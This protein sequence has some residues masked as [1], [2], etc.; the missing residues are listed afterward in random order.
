M[1]SKRIIA[2]RIARLERDLG[3][4]LEYHSISQVTRNNGH[5]N[6]LIDPE[7]GATKRKLKPDEV[8]WIRNERA[9]CQVDFLYYA[10]RYAIVKDWQNRLVRFHP[11]VAQSIL[12]DIMADLEEQGRAIAIMILKARQLGMSTG[13]EI[14]VGHRPQFYPQVN[15]TVASSDPDKS[16][17]MA[18][19]MELCWDHMPWFLMP[20]RT[21][22]KVGELIEYGRQN[23]G[24]AI[25]HGNQFSGISRGT[26]PT[27]AH[28]SE[29]CDY[30]DPAGLIDAS[31][32]R[33][34]HES[35]WMF[36]VLES[37]A[38]G[39]HNWWHNTWELSKQGWKEGTARLY[40]LFLPWFVGRDIYPTETWLR[41]RP[42]PRKW[43]PSELT[44]AHAA[45]AQ[46]YVR[47]NDLLRKHLGENWEMPIEQKW[48][49]E[50]ERQQYSQKKM[51]AQFYSEMPADDIEAFQSTNYSVFDVEVISDYRERVKPDPLAVYAVMTPDIPERLKPARRTIDTNQKPLQIN[52]TLKT[53]HRF[54]A[55]LLPLKFKGYPGFDW[56]NKLILW[57][58]PQAGEE[59]GIG[60]DLSDGVGKDNSVIEVLRK[61]TLY[62]NDAQVAEWA[63]PFVN[64]YDLPPIAFAIGSLFTTRANP[65][66]THGH[67]TRRQPKMVVEVNRNGESTQLEL[68][69]M[70]WTN[71]HVWIRYDAKKIRATHSQKIGWTT[72]AWSR[73]MMMDL[74]VKAFRDQYIDVNSPYLVDEMSDLEATE[75]RQSLRAAYGGHDDRIMAT[76]IVLF[77]MHALE[78]KGTQRNLMRERGEN[79]NQHK[80]YPTYVPPFQ[81]DQDEDGQT[82]HYKPEGVSELEV[83]VSEG[84]GYGSIHGLFQRR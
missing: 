30:D 38:S 57:E 83:E 79:R 47:K 59:Y 63:S 11:N 27:V 55:D 46:A 8:A 84:E 40:P 24:V 45:R 65:V 82:Y 32:L 43:V 56:T 71:F 2:E 22:Y 12:Y 14:A 20:V 41:A 6:S 26:T 69:K 66:E 58:M 51:L 31:L 70:G 7:T 5:F 16:A 62:Q 48:F 21:R 42:I 80:V 4:K 64:A 36:L 76:G 33:A 28:L 81:M 39:R 23:S 1:Y 60:V 77:S 44:L 68:R 35:P 15:A 18:K 3:L 72:N 17:L 75:D 61:G 34:M 10:T 74:L 29:V 78:L 54:H 50:V 67:D 37:T 19:M 13:T 9:L 49:W 53:G 52:A 25:Q 73:P